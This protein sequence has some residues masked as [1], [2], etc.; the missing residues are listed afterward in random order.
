MLRLVTEEH[1]PGPTRSFEHGSSLPRLRILLYHFAAFGGVGGVEFTIRDLESGF[2]ERDHAVGLLHM[3]P[4]RRPQTESPRGNPIWTVQ[5]PS[6]P[7]WLRPRSWA[8]AARSTAQLDAAIR[9]FAPDV[10][11]VHFPSAQS[12]PILGVSKAHRRRWRLVVTFHGSDLAED[13]AGQSDSFR[14]QHKLV[15]AADAITAVSSALAARAER[16]HELTAGSVD[17]IHNGVDPSWLVASRTKVGAHRKRV[18]FVGKL[19]AV[20]GPDILVEAW[21]RLGARRKNAVL[22]LAG[23][24][25]FRARL[26]AAIESAGIAA[27]VELLGAQ[28]HEQLRHLYG[29]ATCLVLPSRSESFGK[30]ILEAAAG[31]VPCVAARVGGVPEVV[32]DG[33]TGMLVAS[34]SPDALA[35]A[36]ARMLEM[37]EEARN[38]LGENARDRVST[39]FA[40][41]KMLDG[42]EAVYRGEENAL[43]D[44]A[45]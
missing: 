18:L 17:V 42:Y 16:H 9:A 10:I 14:W 12:I 5:Q 24:G 1:G 31:G 19:D 27:S 11:H 37:P 23:D 2:V 41:S 40:T 6:Y 8:S 3:T 34:E 13:P 32:V 4:E 30:V 20:K 36:L 44:R 29:T 33:V 28:S 45:G 35:E 26:D 25:P 38:A 7:K 39:M 22:T 43:E 21:N 15:C